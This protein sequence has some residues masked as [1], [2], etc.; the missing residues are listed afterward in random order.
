MIFDPQVNSRARAW[1]WLP[2]EQKDRIWRKL[3]KDF[4]E[5]FYIA[6]VEDTGM[7][8]LFRLRSTLM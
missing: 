8:C 3:Q 4:I 6:P 1:C 5:Q 7:V 2:G